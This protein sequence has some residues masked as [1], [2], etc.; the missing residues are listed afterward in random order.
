MYKLFSPYEE[1]A[2]FIRLQGANRAA[3]REDIMTDGF[4]CKPEKRRRNAPDRRFHHGGQWSGTTIGRGELGCRLLLIAVFLF[5]LLPVLPLHA[6]EDSARL[7]FQKT[8]GISSNRIHVVAKGECLDIIIRNRFGGKPI[9]HSVIR[10]LNPDIRNL[11]RIYPGQKI[12]L[13]ESLSVTGEENAVP[14]T[15]YR[16]RR[17]DSLSRIVR[18]EMNIPTSQ[19]Y[20]TYQAIR[21]L[22]PG[23][24]D[25]NR[26]LVGQ[27]LRLP[28]VST[29]VAEAP[30]PEKT[31]V[32]PQQE[33][34]AKE[35]EMSPAADFLSPIIR[36]VIGRMRGAVSVT[37]SFFIPL[38]ENTQITIDCSQLPVIELPDGTT[39]I[40]DFGDRFSENL[41]GMIRQSWPNYTFL[42]S[43][44]LRDELWALYAI[45]RQSPNFTMVRVEKPLPLTEK[46][47]SLISPDWIITGKET[48]SGTVYRQ[49]VFLLDKEEQPIPAEIRA[50]IEKS[51]VTVT[52]IAEGGVISYGDVPSAPAGPAVVDLRNLNG[53]AFVEKLLAILDEAP[54]RN[55]EVSVFNQ[56]N[57]GFNLSV[58]ADLLVRKNG[59]Q[60]IFQTRRIP[61]QFVQVLR[62]SNT[63]IIPIGENDQGRPLIE[64]VL[65][66]LGMP[67]SFGFFSFRVPDEE[68]KRSRLTAS[69]SSLRT[70]KED[71]PI[72]LIDFDIPSS[73]L[74]FITG[75]HEGRVVRY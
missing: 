5:L 44:F 36:P 9:P 3:G 37:G 51:S 26:I 59:K 2:I 34:A 45:I 39:V 69:F 19:V 15:T 61:E 48:A 71:K 13:P 63:E 52:E 60:I 17:G 6:R 12:V 1:F 31:D 72:Y 43:N 56:E 40:L 11:N 64:A 57:D 35:P 75:R 27:V 25:V 49:G 29:S 67:C 62:K 4:S 28:A 58:T 22:N 23:I 10:H 24:S 14:I 73:G 30:A 46:P 66:G 54:E 74:P 38:R 20:A 70:M 32:V 50:F 33:N 53:I 55:A 68:N 7:V 47:D 16:V 8:A 65:H 18:T 21:K 42:S 41:K